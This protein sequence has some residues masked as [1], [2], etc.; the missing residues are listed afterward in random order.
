MDS[1]GPD[2]DFADDR[3]GGQNRIFKTEEAARKMVK[4]DLESDRGGVVVLAAEKHSCTPRTIRNAAN[5][6]GG[7]RKAETG[8]FLNDNSRQ[9]RVAYA[10]AR[11]GKNHKKMCWAD[12]TLLELPPAPANIASVAGGQFYEAGAEKAAAQEANIDADVFSSWRLRLE[13]ADIFSEAAQVQAAN[14][15]GECSWQA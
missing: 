3:T 6:V 10:D 11:L 1:C 15:W 4:R 12:H 2:A 14:G 9:K 8:I 13:Q 5:R 7:M